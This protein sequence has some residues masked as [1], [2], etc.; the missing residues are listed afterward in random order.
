MTIIPIPDIHGLT[1]WK[2]IVEEFSNIDKF[3]FL[4][5]YLDPYQNI[6]EEDLINNLLQ[7]INFKITHPHQ[8]ELLLGN[9]DTHYFCSPILNH[10]SRLAFVTTVTEE[11]AIAAPAI[12]G[13]NNSP[14]NGYNIPAAMGIPKIL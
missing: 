2:N 4:G 10:L 9:H 12:I 13:F 7:I 1:K 3:V 11:K 6:S 14:I 8:V 5:D